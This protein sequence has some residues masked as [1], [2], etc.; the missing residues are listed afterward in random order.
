MP[1]IIL[2]IYDLFSSVSDI[3]ECNAI[4][5]LCAGGKCVNTIGSFIC[6]CPDGKARNP[7]TNKC[8][9]RNE[10]LEENICQDGRCVNTDPGFFCLCNPGFIQSQDR[11]FCIGKN[12]FLILLEMVLLIRIYFCPETFTI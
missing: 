2:N 5:E 6:E 4:P 3:D 8:D 10:C 7:D 11:T 12:F 1:S 9:D